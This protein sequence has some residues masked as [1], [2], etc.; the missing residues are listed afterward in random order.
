MKASHPEVAVA[1]RANPGEMLRKARE[2]KNWALTDV[3]AQLNLTAQALRQL[4]AGAFDQ[5]PGHTFSR[6]YIRSYAKLLGMDGNRLVQEFDQYTGTDAQGS[7]VASLGR[8]E[9]P[10]RASQGLLQA[11]SVVVLLGLGAA[12]FFWWQGE[13]HEA[14]GALSGANI[15][16]VEVDAADG[17]TE[18]HPLSELEDQAVAQVQGGEEGEAPVLPTEVAPE[19]ATPGEPA[20]A[21][22]QAAQP[23]VPAAPAAAAP[24][25]AAGTA[26][27][28][29]VPA[30]TPPAAAPALPNNPA[31]AVTEAPVAPAAP[32]VAPAESAAAVAPA[33]VAGM[34]RVSL[35]FSADCWA[36]VTDADGKLLLSALKR[37]GESLEV[38]GKAPLE[39]RLG[40][41][42]GAVVSFNGQQVDIAPF[43]HGETARLKLGQ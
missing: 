22:G 41:A 36:Q 7:S 25:Q 20:A 21:E 12:G 35:M 8:V 42:R 2:N 37:K 13:S 6:G 10:A 18:I 31:P 23:A 33:A 14:G 15:E 43:T 9:E 27:A 19:A 40:Y 26:P 34:G 38:T 5:L 1:T 4:E 3:A 32:A 30:L 17:T 29:A 28:S 11:F 39:L 24:A 16:H